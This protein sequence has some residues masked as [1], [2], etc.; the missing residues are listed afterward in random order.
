MTITQSLKTILHADII[1]RNACMPMLVNT[2]NVPQIFVVCP[3]DHVHDVL[4]SRESHLP[5]LS[6]VGFTKIWIHRHG[7]QTTPRW[8]TLSSTWRPIHPEQR[9]HSLMLIKWIWTRIGSIEADQPAPILG[10]LP[11][12]VIPV[13][14]IHV[15]FK[16]FA[17]THMDDLSHHIGI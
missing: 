16:Q 10:C 13:C 5:L 9:P 3:L 1:K 11:F 6:L 12:R 17:I 2:V 15:I 4:P 14:N 8:N 7:R